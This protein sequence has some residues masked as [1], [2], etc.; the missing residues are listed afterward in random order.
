M[1][2]YGKWC[3]GVVRSICE[4]MLQIQ[5]FVNDKSY[6]N[7]WVGRDCE[8]IAESGRMQNL[9]W[10]EEVPE[11]LH[12]ESVENNIDENLANDSS[13]HNE[14]GDYSDDAQIRHSKF[15]KIYFKSK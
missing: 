6:N 12:A 7:C 14:S 9:K 13:T 8:Y 15:Q 11:L 4:E 1:A 2:Q 3:T 5:T 10:N